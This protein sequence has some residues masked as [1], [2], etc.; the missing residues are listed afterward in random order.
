MALQQAETPIHLSPDDFQAVED[1]IRYGIKFRFFPSIQSS[2]AYV[3]EFID[4]E[5]VVSTCI[6]SDVETT[7]A[8]NGG[9]AAYAEQIIRPRVKA[10]LANRKTQAPWP[11]QE[12]AAIVGKWRAL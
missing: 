6:D 5:W 7:I 12:A 2:C 3:L 11:A 10:W 9:P 8:Q 4:N 1:G